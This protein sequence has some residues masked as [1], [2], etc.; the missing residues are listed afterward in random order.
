MYGADFQSGALVCVRQDDGTRMWQSALSTTGVNKERGTS[1]ASVY[2]I[3]ADGS[4]YYL[5]S[6]TGD[7][8]SARLTPSGYEE[9]GRFHAIDPTNIASGRNVLWTF[10]AIADGCLFVRNDQE[11]RCFSMASI[12]Q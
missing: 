12:L 2:L 3:K 6:E 10:P 4:N 7:F 9:T 1:N 5:L 11:L 8:I